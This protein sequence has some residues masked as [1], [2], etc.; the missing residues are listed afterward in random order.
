MS[1]G[2]IDSAPLIIRT[3]NDDSADN[4]FLLT[5][6]DYPVSSNHMLLTTS[7]GTMASSDALVQ[8]SMGMSSIAVSTYQGSS[9]VY[10]TFYAS[11]LQ[12]PSA[13]Y[14]TIVKTSF[15]TSSMTAST[16]GID[17]LTISTM[18][19]ST[20]SPNN[21]TATYTAFGSTVQTSSISFSTLSGNSFVTNSINSVSSLGASSIYTT[22]LNA[23]T[24]IGDTLRFSSITVT[25]AI[26]TNATFASIQGS[27]LGTSTLVTSSLL[28]STIYTSPVIFSTLQGSTLTTRIVTYNSTL[29]A[30]SIYTD[31]LTFPVTTGDTILISTINVPLAFI[32]SFVFSTAQG[33]TL[34]L[35]TLNASTLTISSIT[36]S[37]FQGS[38]MLFSTLTASSMNGTGI[39]YST[40]EGSTLLLSSITISTLTTNPILYS[41][42]S[43]SSVNAIVITSTLS[44][45]TILLNTLAFSTVQDDTVFLSTFYLST[46]SLNYAAGSTLQGSTVIAPA[47]VASS[48]NGTRVTW[49]TN[50][51][52][53]VFFSTMTASSIYGGSIV[54]STLQGSTVSLSTTIFS[55]LSASTMSYSTLQG[56]TSV[57]NDVNSSTLQSGSILF[58]TLQLSTSNVS[59]LTSCTINTSNSNVSTLQGSTLVVSTLSGFTIMTDSIFFSTMSGSSMIANTITANST[60]SDNG[61]KFF[62]S[63]L[64]N[65]SQISTS[66]LS[67]LSVPSTLTVSTLYRVNPSSLTYST[68]TLAAGLQSNTVATSGLSCSS[69][70]TANINVTRSV[71]NEPVYGQTVKIESI[72]NS[73]PVIVKTSSIH[74]KLDAPPS[75]QQIYTFG[76]SIPDRWM[77]GGSNF[78]NSLAYSY[79][80][81]NWTGLGTNIFGTCYGIAWNGT[82][83]V[84]VGISGPGAPN[85]IAYSYDGIRWT[86][87]GMIIF[88]YSGNGIAWNGAMWVAVGWGDNTIAY[89]YDGINWIGLGTSI[90]TGSGADVAWNG[91]MWIAVGDGSNAIAY[92]YDG[93]NWIGLGTSIFTSSGADVAWNGSMWIAVGNG[94]NSIAY[95]YDGINWIGLGAI[96][97]TNG[98]YRI[99]WNG[100]MWIAVGWGTSSIAYSYDGI[101]WTGLGLNIFTLRATSIAWNGTMWVAGGIGTNAIA[102]SYDGINWTGLGSSTLSGGYSIAYNGRRPHT[103]TFPSPMTV[104]TGLGTNTL[105]YSVDGMNWTGNGTAIFNTKG[106]G[107]ATNGSVWVA[108]GSVTNTLAYSTNGTTWQGLGTSIFSVEG[109][110]IAWNGSMWVAVGSGTNSIAYSYDGITW[111]GLGSSTFTQ[112]NGIAWSGSVW[113]AVGSGTHTIAYSY[114]SIAWIGLGNTIFGT[115]GNGIAWNGSIWV[116][117]GTGTNSIAYSND[118]ITWIGLDT[119]FVPFAYLPLDNSSADTFGNLSTPTTNSVTYSNSIYKVGSYSALFNNSAGSNWPSNY[120]V[121][122]TPAPLYNPTAITVSFW[123]YPTSYGSYPSIPLVFN[124]GRLE[125]LSF[126]ISPYND[127]PLDV[128]FYTSTS[129]FGVSMTSYPTVIPLNT[130]THVVFTFSIVNGSGIGTL[131]LNGNF[132]VSTGIGGSGVLGLTYPGGAMT[133]LTLGCLKES[134]YPNQ[135]SAYAGY[136]DDVRIYTTALTPSLIAS[137]YNSPSQLYLSETPRLFT[138]SGNSVAWNG[139]R[140]VAVGSGGNTIVY[141]IDGITWTPAASSC[142][143][144]AGNGVTWNGTRWI[145]TGSGTNTIGYSSDGSTWYKSQH[146]TPNQ[147]SLAANTWINNGVTWIASASSNN[148]VSFPAYGAFNNDSGSTSIYSWA[149]PVYYSTGAGGG[150]YTRSPPITTTVQRGIGSLTGEWLQ[151]QS[152][153]PL[154]LSSYTYGCGSFGQFPKTYYIIGSN[155]NTIWYPIQSCIMTTNPLTA[156]FTVCGTYIIVNQSGTQTIYGGQAGSGTFTIYP[157]YTTT[158]YTYFRIIGQTLWDAGT[159]GNMEIGEWYLNFNAADD[160]VLSNYTNYSTTAYGGATVTTSTRNLNAYQLSLV[161]GSSQYLQTANFTPTINGLSFSFWYKSTTSGSWARI[162]DFGNGATSNNIL[163]S[164]NANGS[165]SVYFENFYGA[166]AS[167]TTLNDINYNDNIWR[168]VTWTLTYAAAG[169]TTSTWTIYINGVLKMT[170]TSKS[171]PSTLVTRTLS[172]IGRSNWGVD[173]YYNGMID[174]FRI[175]NNVL[176]DQQVSAIYSDSGYTSIFSTAGSSIASN[177]NSSGTVFIQHPVIAVGQGIHTIAYSPDGIQWTGLGA[178]IFD[179]AG[180]GVAWNGSI[181]VAVGF[182]NNHTIAY[183]I[184]GLRWTGLG[185]LVFSEQANG[186]AW[187]G[188]LWVAVGNGTNKVAYSTDGMTWIG[189]TTGNAIFTNGANSVA[190]NGK[191]WVVVGQGT[192]SIAYSADGI[193]WTAIGS[194][195]FSTKGNGVAWTGSLW[196]AVGSGI[197]RIASSVDGT[198]WTAS[199][200]GNSI[201]TSAN[202]VTWNGV[203][204]VAVGIGSSHTL[205]YSDNGTTWTGLGKTLFSTTGYGVCWTGTRFVAVGQGTNAI[206][207]SQ[208]GITWYPAL[209]SIFTQGNGVAGNPRIGATVCD[210]Q[211]VLNASIGGSNTLDIISDTYYN[212]G[213]TN[214]SATI[215]AQTYGVA[216]TDGTVSS[217]AKTQPD[218]P[219]SVSAILY[220]AGAATGTNVSFTYPVNKGGG[221]DLYYASATDIVGAQPTIIASYGTSPIYLSGLIP[222][223]T[224]HIS[225]YSSNSAG[226]SAATFTSSPL[227]YQVT[228]GAPTL[229]SVALTPTGNPSG[230]L[231]SFTPPDTVASGGVSS[232]TATAYSGATV[233]SSVTGP[234]SPLTINGLTP[235]TTYTYKVVA[236]NTSGTS[237]ASSNVPSLTYYTK[238]TKPTFVS[239]AFDS[240]TTPTGVNVTF[241]ASSDMGGGTLTYVAT[242]YYNGSFVSQSVPSSSGTLY[243]TGLPAGNAYTYRIV[244]TNIAVP[245][246]VSDASDPSVAT[247]YYT[248]PS[249]PTNVVATRSPPLAPTGVNVTFDA[250]SSTGGSVLTYTATAFLNGVATAF[251]ASGSSNSLTITGLTAGTSYTYKVVASNNGSLTNTSTASAALTYYTKPIKPTISSVTLEPSDNPTGVNVNFTPFTLLSDRGGAS[252]TYVATAYYDGNFVSQSVSSSSGTLYVTGLLAGYSYTY[253]I[254]ATNSVVPTIVSDASDPSSEMMYYTQPSKPTNVVATLSPVLDPTG[255]SVTFTAST[256]A[257]GGTLTYTAKSYAGVTPGPN[258]ISGGANTFTFT[259]LTAGTAYTFVVTA[260]NGGVTNASDPS[261][262]LI[263]YTKPTKPTISS[264]VLDLPSTPDGV[265]VNF[266]PLTGSS[267]GG[268][269]LTYTAT[270]YLNGVATSFITSGPSSPL[271]I[272]GLTAGTT[273]TYKLTTNNAAVTSDASDPATLLYQTNPSVPRSIMASATLNTTTISW[274][275]P[276]ADGGSAITSYRVVSSPAGYDSGLIGVSTLSVVATGLTNGIPYTFT[277][278]ATNSG[279]LT[280]SAT[281]SAVTPYT[282]PSAPIE[283]NSTAASG[284]LTLNWT[285][286]ITGGRDITGYKII[287]TTTSTTRT[288]PINSYVWNGLINGSSYSFTVA[289]TNDDI[290]YGATAS[291]SNTVSNPGFIYR[292]FKAPSPLPVLL[293]S[294]GNGGVGGGYTDYSGYYLGHGGGGAGGVVVSTMNNIVAERGE[295]SNAGSEGEGGTGFGAG[296]GGAIDSYENWYNDNG[297]IYRHYITKL[298]GRGADGFAYLYIDYLD[299]TGNELFYRAYYESTTYQTTFTKTGV[300]YIVVMGGGGGGSS[301]NKTTL[302]AGSGGNAGYLQT[303]TVNIVKDQIAA[304]TIG[305]GG[306]SDTNGGT[307]SVVIN[308]TP[309]TAN[310][311]GAGGTGDAGSSIGGLGFSSIDGMVKAAASGTSA[312]NAGQGTVSFSTAMTYAST[313][314]TKYFNDN[315]SLFSTWTPNYTGTTTDTSSINSSTGGIVP[316]DGTFDNYS[317]EWFGYFKAPSNG[318]YTFYTNTIGPSYVWFGTTAISGYTTSNALVNNGTDHL[319]RERSGITTT[320]T[321]GTFYPIRCQFGDNTG[322]DSYQ[323]SLTLPGSTTRIYNINGYIVNW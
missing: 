89:S 55:T 181:W 172:Y 227:L 304:I 314:V 312:G 250:P 184:D 238:P 60:F 107:V 70:T 84:A 170:A 101:S 96:I 277:I 26:A 182:G 141:S 114:N 210:S 49:S 10:S 123:M 287:N 282:L 316:N 129:P 106:N 160:I 310:G 284:Q 175:Y 155:N 261:S 58:S 148:S 259:G 264:V 205:A 231:V 167:N 78:P 262:A 229:D 317:V 185:T 215:Q 95:S 36:G 298:G 52:N 88:R 112:G 288:S 295:Y 118:G 240:P 199:A 54:F 6:Y 13:F 315:P 47:L 28:G 128:N 94:T 281:S 79:N 303:Y 45:S 138:S 186:I 76:P 294:A 144:T 18:T 102:Y 234:S 153:V 29:S 104:A 135:G 108:T 97:F 22:I 64:V 31:V 109:K 180:Y 132:Q 140:W 257:G 159:N 131:Y 77:G 15:T 130:W 20:V 23:S 235:G 212:K 232:Y 286:P 44:G 116:A 290:N 279:T 179:T 200:T 99:A 307:T 80:G 203:R 125:G 306:I 174:D 81:I 122:P 222:G 280:S 7:N 305:L 35:S 8:P 242:A 93:I 190:W 243:V 90:F 98:C 134:Q 188:S 156:N 211:I 117:V 48:M 266:T 12:L 244:A 151:L 230:V 69:I 92:S 71:V 196:V 142:F 251:T 67:T 270:A 65:A 82:I 221:I 224:Y 217:V 311:G 162:F 158:A 121:Y 206:A 133:L 16:I 207:Y 195:V 223:K 136:I 33:S 237:A 289:A 115:Q 241:G 276:L 103:I 308:S 274:M 254:V 1:L 252:L 59:T 309:Y 209:N 9:V 249:T 74:A 86:G 87:L 39:V 145:A 219:T 265:N 154:V 17:I 296:G 100:T 275:A 5:R 37:T 126:K 168:H 278:T 320:L 239:I 268:G 183:S 300:V 256:N 248:Q 176:T 247:P 258:G 66:Q 177:N 322:T 202:S 220:P 105:S 319:I 323:F 164:I 201:F 218:P 271:K 127:G 27:T 297:D 152:S 272:T 124:D 299:G 191:Q 34:L 208:D 283:L 51:G 19:V 149:S 165:N 293:L 253:R 72:V 50:A 173:Q 192:N 43:G 150:A 171:Y 73:S 255:V 246:I 75:N 269:T 46:L 189:S 193:T 83:W 313:N 233:V 214:F 157:P 119:T 187:N 301:F 25:N 3:Y 285:V 146:I 228:P 30:S 57:S 21:V 41:T 194:T 110:G 61:T 263:Y 143:T 4:T 226:Q 213:Y 53:T 318:I 40:L 216:T 63:Y 198:A 147:T 225:V 302:V 169:A 2:P 42:M 273:Y 32:N 204:W 113:V 236:T 166:V 292:I 120:I 91:S 14:D 68:L 163:C 38:T 56:N 62:S 267:T 24:I 137:L 197:N 178:S 11:T 139:E 245:T 291:I 321:A 85:Y 260:F 161:A 111:I